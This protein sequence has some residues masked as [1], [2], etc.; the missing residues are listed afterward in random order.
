MHGIAHLH[1]ISIPA[2]L[3]DPLSCTITGLVSKLSLLTSTA[4]VKQLHPYSRNI[5]VRWPYFFL[6]LP[7]PIASVASMVILWESR[8]AAVLSQRPITICLF[9]LTA[10]CIAGFNFTGPF[11]STGAGT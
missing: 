6:L 7:F 1:S 4:I 10:A 3:A 9:L 2:L 11:R 8:N 5:P